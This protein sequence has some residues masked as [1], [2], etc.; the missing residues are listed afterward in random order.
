MDT[1]FLT[2]TQLLDHFL[3][4]NFIS[5]IEIIVPNK[6]VKIYFLGNMDYEKMVCSD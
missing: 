1:G 3:N 2:D 4:R 6:V 5:D